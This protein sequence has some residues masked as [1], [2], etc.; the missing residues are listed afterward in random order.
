MGAQVWQKYANVAKERD[1]V[2]GTI[3]DHLAKAQELGL[4]I[5][6]K[7][8][9]P[10]RADTKLIKEA[11]LATMDADTSIR[12]AKLTPAKTFL[13]QAGE[14]YGFDDLKLVRLFLK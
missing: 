13:D 7:H 2:P 6:F 10:K 14:T 9:K 11:F 4:A 1:L 12:E 5:D 8:I 3:I